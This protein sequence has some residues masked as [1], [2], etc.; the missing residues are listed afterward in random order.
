RGGVADAADERADLDVRQGRVLRRRTAAG[1]VRLG[2]VSRAAAEFDLAGRADGDRIAGAERQAGVRPGRH[3]AHGYGN[4]AAT[5][6]AAAR[7]SAGHLIAA[8]GFRPAQ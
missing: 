7:V 8:R 4:R 6:A 2:D 3:A 5:P 1:A